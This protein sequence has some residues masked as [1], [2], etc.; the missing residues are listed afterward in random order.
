MSTMMRTNTAMVKRFIFG[1][2]CDNCL[3]YYYIIINNIIFLFV[4]TFFHMGCNLL[5]RVNE[6]IRPCV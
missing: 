3:Y 2:R 5:K 4:L 1:M 6:H